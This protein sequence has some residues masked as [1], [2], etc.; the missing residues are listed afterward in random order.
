[1]ARITARKGMPSTMLRKDEFAARVKRRFYDPAFD[2]LQDQIS[3]IVD[4]AWDG[5]CNS[6]KSPRTSSERSAS[7][8]RTR[9]SRTFQLTITTLKSG[10]S[11]RPP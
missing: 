4:A 11:S 3:S 1:M 9:R 7:R 2:A 10:R 6:R 5:Y 8:H